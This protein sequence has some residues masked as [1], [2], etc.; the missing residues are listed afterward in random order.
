[1]EPLSEHQKARLAIR[2]IKTTSDALAL[3]G[4]YKPAGRSGQTLADGLRM[5]SPEIYGSMNSSTI[6]AGRILIAQA[7]YTPD[8]SLRFSAL[9]C[10]IAIC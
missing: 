3:R 10:R 6:Y 1:M 9:P 5:L 4:Y 8:L 2:I 7:M